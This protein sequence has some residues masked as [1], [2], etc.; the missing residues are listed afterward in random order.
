MCTMDT[1]GYRAGPA[2]LGE[3]VLVPGIRQI[4]VAVET[5]YEYFE[6][7][8][9]LEAAGAYMLQLYA[10]ISDI[11]IRDLDCT[12]LVTYVRLWDD[13]NDLWDV[14]NLGEFRN[15]WNDNM[16][17]VHRDV[18]QFV[19][20]NRFAPWGGV[21][22]LNGLCNG[23]SYSVAAYSLGFYESTDGPSV[24]NRDITV[25]AHELG[26]NAGTPH[27]H[28]LGIDT[29]NEP[30]TTPQRGSIMAYCGQTF[31][32]GTANHDLRFHTTV[33]DVIANFVST[34]DCLA[35]DCNLN[36]IDDEL[37]IA[38]GTSDDA[39][40]NGIP[41]ECEDCNANGTFDD[42]DIAN[43]T[44]LDLNANG[45][46]DECEPDCNANQIPDDLDIS[47]VA[48]HPL[49]R[50]VRGRH[51]LDGREPR[52]HQRRLGARRAHQRSGLELRPRV[53]L[54]RLRPVL[55]DRQRAGQHRHRRGR[56]APDLQ[57]L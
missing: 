7:F 42:V 57:R 37:D 43:G 17:D 5:D 55:G 49:R 18:A 38:D 51:G 26:H 50:H 3:P 14:P 32:G 36:G 23:N 1:S 52:R 56:R 41:D 54:R 24:F 28:D 21:A 48:G 6:P 20:G 10:A 53:R 8:G 29:C 25:T 15:Y 46:P 19:S 45:I 35:F 4:E 34:R 12:V 44:S 47:G 33:Q 31:T 11:Y 9:D 2:G 13:P 39:N 40:E 22:Y 27:T 30:D 16:G